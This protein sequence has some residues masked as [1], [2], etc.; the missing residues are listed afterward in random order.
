MEVKAMN[1]TLGGEFSVPSDL[2]F[3]VFLSICPFHGPSQT[4]PKLIEKAEIAQNARKYIAHELAKREQ[5]AHCIIK[6]PQ[7]LAAFISK[8]ILFM[9]VKKHR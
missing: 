1:D 6:C 5:G 8:E 9:W 7:M 3:T 2:V 4:I